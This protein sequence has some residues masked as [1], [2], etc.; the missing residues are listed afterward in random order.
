MFVTRSTIMTVT[1]LKNVL[2]FSTIV[3]VI[4]CA[5][6]PD[7]C[8]QYLQKQYVDA[9]IQY[10]KLY[11][12]GRLEEALQMFEQAVKQD[13]NNY[14]AINYLGAYK[15]AL[16]Q[17]TGYKKTELLEVYDLYQKSINICNDFRIGH[18]NLIQV[19]SD[20]QYD[21][22]L[23]EHLEYYH[24]KYPKRSNLLRHGGESLFRL[25]RIEAS[26]QYLN[27][28]I[29]MDSTDAMAYVFKA[30]CLI[31]QKK[32]KEAMAELNHGLSLDSVSLGYHER[33]HLYHELGNIDAAINDFNTAIRL[34]PERF[35]SYIGLG[36]IEVER[37]NYKL[38]CN[39]FHQA[40]VVYP[41][42]HVA[43]SWILK[44]CKE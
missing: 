42:N 7:I 12:E 4:G 31:S 13:T 9:N 25:G 32:M 24:S 3:M 14:I 34:Y 37:K 26:L 21:E 15:Y 43:D 41:E 17:K 11:K 33:G 6:K 18:F 39:Y 23:L 29:L 19:Q 16:C 30:K 1:D 20:L 5:P 36:M 22:E 10:E 28:A 40:K 2:F 27:E 44:Y 8:K 38:A 35:E